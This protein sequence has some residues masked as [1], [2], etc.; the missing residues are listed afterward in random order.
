[1]SRLNMDRKSKC[2]FYPE[3]TGYKKDN[4]RRIPIR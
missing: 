2:Q 4:G 3:E 1:M